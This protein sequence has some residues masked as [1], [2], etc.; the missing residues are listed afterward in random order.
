MRSSVERFGVLP[1][2][3]VTGALLLGLK[4]GWGSLGHV[5]LIRKMRRICWGDPYHVG[6]LG[7]TWSCSRWNRNWKWND[8]WNSLLVRCVVLQGRRVLTRAVA[9]RRRRAARRCRAAS[10][11][12][13]AGSGRRRRPRRETTTSCRCTSAPPCRPTSVIHAIRAS[14]T[15]VWVSWPLPPWHPFTV[16]EGVPLCLKSWLWLKSACYS[17]VLGLCRFFSA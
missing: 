8:E 5:T 3:G 12:S 1:A 14:S 6:H 17:T 2:S 7:S 10:R 16:R 13:T 15:P 9:R 4:V 11:R